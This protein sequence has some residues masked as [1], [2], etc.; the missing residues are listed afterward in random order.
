MSVKHRLQSAAANDLLWLMATANWN[1]LH[2]DV[3]LGIPAAAVTEG[4]EGSLFSM[5]TFSFIARDVLFILLAILC[6][7]F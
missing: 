6:A 2:Q 3:S 1:T 4:G 5:R 7:G